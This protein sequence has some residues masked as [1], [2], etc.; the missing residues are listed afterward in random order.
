[1]LP[2]NKP[3]NENSQDSFRKTIRSM[4]HSTPT[5]TTSLIELKETLNNGRIESAQSQHQSLSMQQYEKNPSSV[6][7]GILIE[8]CQSV[9]TQQCLKLPI[10][11]VKGVSFDHFIPMGDI[12]V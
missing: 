3:R 12:E 10:S 6:I 4:D 11:V 8:Q 1:M 5:L 7:K 2:N 9:S